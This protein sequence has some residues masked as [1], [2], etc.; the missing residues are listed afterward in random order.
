MKPL[1]LVPTF[2]LLWCAASSPLAA[3]A[4]PR[5][6]GTLPAN[7]R[8]TLDAIRRAVWV[9]WF[10]GD[11]AKL[12]RILTPELVAVSPDGAHWQSLGQTLAA[13]AAYKASGARFVDVT[14][15][16]TTLHRFG[17]VVVMFSH[18]AVTTES[19]GQR[20]VQAGRATEVFVRRDGRWLHTSWHLDVM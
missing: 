2:M 4:A 19:G 18:Y 13:S 15:D 17:D 10:T 3:Q 9:D 16:S 5:L 1:L 12:R 11:T 20:A 7:E 14:F 8:A 6:S